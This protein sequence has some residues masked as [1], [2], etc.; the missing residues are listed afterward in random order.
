MSEKKYRAGISAAETAVI[1]SKITQTISFVPA[2]VAILS[3]LSSLPDVVGE[4]GERSYIFKTL[5]F[6]VYYTIKTRV[7]AC[8]ARRWNDYPHLI[9]EDQSAAPS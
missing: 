7:F 1:T 3:T 6:M 4:S 5:V 8:A 9:Y 2:F